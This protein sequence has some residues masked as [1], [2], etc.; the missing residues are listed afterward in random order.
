MIK[1]EH[2]SF[3]YFRRDEDGNVTDVVEAVKNLSLQVKPGEFIGI[4]GRN[5]SG[6]STFAKL[7]NALLEPTEG[8]ILIA[9]MDSHDENYTWQIR[10]NAG[11]VFQN[12][13]NQIIG[14]VVE[15]DVAFGPENLGVETDEIIKR[16]ENALEMVGM[17]AYRLQSPNR[18]SG[19]QKQRVAIAG[20]LAMHPKCIIF[21]ESTAMLDPQ[22]RK[23]VLD[24]AHSLNQEQNITILYIT[25]DMDEIIDA[26]RVIV[27]H[28]GELVLE[29][30][31]KEIFGAGQTLE[32]YGLAL[33]KV[34]ELAK[35]LSQNG[36][37]FS[38]SIL[39]PDE[40]SREMNR[41]KSYAKLNE[42]ENIVTNGSLSMSA[43]TEYNDITGNTG[44]TGR[45]G[46]VGNPHRA[47]NTGITENIEN[48]KQLRDEAMKYGLVLDHIS[49]EY[50]PNTIYAYTA[51]KDVTLTL[52]KGEFVAIIG[53]TGS[54]KST[55]IQQLNGLLRPTDG[56]IYFE[57]KDIYENGYNRT[58]LREK[59]GL[60]FQYPEYQLFAET[61]FDDVCFGPK[62]LNLPL[63]EVQQRAF[64]AI[65]A[66]GLQDNVY[67]LSPFELSGGQKRRVAIAGVLAMQPDFL[68]LDE[69]VA[70]LDPAGRKE[71]LEM[72]KHLNEQGMTIVL[73]SHNMEDVAEYAKRIIVMEQGQIVCDGRGTEIFREE[74]QLQ[75]LGLDVPM[76]TRLMKRLKMEGH[77]VNTAIYRMEDAVKELTRYLS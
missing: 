2:V 64:Q 34:T 35:R 15:E 20:V 26:D 36:I 22:G 27:I 13:D 67:D 37:D 73:V 11:M 69:P 31:P 68:I 14:T 32:S 70:G 40:F 12:P 51:L 59:V 3:E 21:D 54:G 4:L 25:H 65:K 39:N 60:V 71:L 45:T 50:S 18:L 56:H 77:E 72:L 74:K 41:V 10:K 57:G 62:N 53:H 76:V 48:E 19:G 49:Y 29:G 38:E 44:I 8:S 58:H 7:L 55:L 47:G 30:T 28:Q 9:G 6:K 42:I 43:N 23:E 1:A 66:V 52:G 75:K 16:V 61:V 46:I 17:A 24:A 33:P 63:L 5:G